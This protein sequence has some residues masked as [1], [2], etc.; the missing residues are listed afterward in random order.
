MVESVPQEPLVRLRNVSKHFGEG[1]TRVDALKD[2]S[3]EV[4]PRQVVALLGPSGSGKTTLLNTIGCVLAPSSGWMQL[5]GDVVYDGRWLRSDLRRL[6]LDKIGFIFQFHNLLPFLDATDN[7]AVVLSLAG[8][9][10][11]VAHRRAVE[12]LDYLEVGHRK[13]AFPAK[14]SGG[15]AQRVAIA[16][17]LA[18]RPRIIL[19]D[20]PTAALD[21]KRAG[22]VMDLLRKLAVE[23]QAAI[24]AV[25]HDEKIF[26]R[27][28]RIFHLRD[29]RLDQEAE[30]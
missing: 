21:S 18:N 22:I 1:E 7:V 17:A 19:A 14:L 25:T 11:R 2:V 27:F 30:G 5:D 10:T 26:D 3:L 24:I 29:G 4:F 20:E 28:D 16:R 13:T 12:L 23:Q 15:E 6:R 8:A 9:N